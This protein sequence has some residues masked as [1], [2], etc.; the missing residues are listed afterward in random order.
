MDSPRP[1][2]KAPNTIYWLI[3]P[4]TLVWPA[5]HLLVF[6]LRFGRLPVEMVRLSAVFLPLGLIS[7]LIFL[8]FLGR[9]RA[10]AERRAVIAGYIIAFPFA[11]LGSL[12]GG[13][14]LT[15]I[16]GVTLFGL[17]PMLVGILGG[18]ALGRALRSR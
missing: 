8:Y 3:I 18:Y 9:A 1:S 10:G 11:L 13:L 7:S 5:I 16:A 2:A 12:A 17:V 6:G 4:L 15:P 14:V